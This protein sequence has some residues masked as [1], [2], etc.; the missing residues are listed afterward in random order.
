MWWSSRHL[1]LPDEF[2]PFSYSTSVTEWGRLPGRSAQ[3]DQE[4]EEAEETDGCEEA[5]GVP[6]VPKQSKKNLFSEWDGSYRV[7]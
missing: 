4:M 7:V 2:L 1:F 6:E 3:Q 5:E